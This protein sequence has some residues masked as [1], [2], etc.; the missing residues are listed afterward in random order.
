MFSFF[1]YHTNDCVRDVYKSWLYSIISKALKR[2]Y[3]RLGLKLTIILII[4]VITTALWENST[5]I[6]PLAMLSCQFSTPA[7]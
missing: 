2:D 3:I 1:L 4:T 6:P 5:R 7:Y